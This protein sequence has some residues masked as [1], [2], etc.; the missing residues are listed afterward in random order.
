MQEFSHEWLNLDET[1]NF[2]MK[3]EVNSNV[4]DLIDTIFYT[5]HG[6]CACSYKKKKLECSHGPDMK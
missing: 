1:N 2:A 4:H 5:F 3:M 6:S